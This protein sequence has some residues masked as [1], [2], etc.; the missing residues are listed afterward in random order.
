MVRA[1]VAGASVCAALA[2]SGCGGGDGGGLSVFGTDGESPR[3]SAEATDRKDPTGPSGGT[4]EPAEAYL[5]EADLENAIL[6]AGELGPG[7]VRG[8]VRSTAGVGGGGEPAEPDALEA[9]LRQYCAPH[10]EQA[11]EKDSKAGRY[12]RADFTAPASADVKY[13]DH[14]L[15]ITVQQRPAAALAKAVEYGQRSGRE[16]KNIPV[17][18]PG[19]PYTLDYAEIP[20]LPPGGDAA[21]VTMTSRNA[22]AAT[23]VS[24]VVVRFGNTAVE[25]EGS[26]DAVEAFMDPAVRKVREL[27]EAKR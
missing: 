7:W 16:C 12:L 15:T 26:P 22:S 20:N 23:V 14:E 24:W 19:N 25:I 27:V 11:D 5:P 21:G 8:P 13:L 4:K 18:E 2:V 17:A 10:R 6:T 3:A 9:A 1:V